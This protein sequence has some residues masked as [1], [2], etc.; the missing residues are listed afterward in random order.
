MR[1]NDN[2]NIIT[3]EVKHPRTTQS[4]NKR[5]ASLDIIRKMKEQTTQKHPADGQT[6]LSRTL[7]K[8]RDHQLFQYA[9]LP[10]GAL[11]GRAQGL[12][13]TH[14]PTQIQPIDRE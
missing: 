9:Y 2:Y 4:A 8:P 6:A 3:G 1:P 12:S 5:F 13:G 14:P 7:G 10:P 11:N